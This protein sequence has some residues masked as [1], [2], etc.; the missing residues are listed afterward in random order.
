M[1]LDCGIYI[2]EWKDKKMNG[3]GNMIYNDGSEYEGYW[4]NDR[5]IRIFLVI[6]IRE[7]DQA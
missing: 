1:K 2:G 3:K 7:M 5:V 4:I 6:F